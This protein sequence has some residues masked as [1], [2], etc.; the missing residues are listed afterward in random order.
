MHS[1]DWEPEFNG[2][3]QR[4][5]DSSDFQTLRSHGHDLKDGAVLTSVSD[6]PFEIS[7]KCSH[8]K[9]AFWFENAAWSTGGIA[10]WQVSEISREDASMMCSALATRDG[11][12]G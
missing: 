7:L 2:A 9:V 12:H 10:R 4:L 8:C 6:V 1:G 11:H 3:R 5:F